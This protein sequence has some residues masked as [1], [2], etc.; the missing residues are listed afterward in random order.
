MTAINPLK[1]LGV[2]DPCAAKHMANAVDDLPAAS[3]ASTAYDGD[4][5]RDIGQ[6]NGAT[7]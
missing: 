5:S 6:E 7:C 3:K 2:D 1:Q 4:W